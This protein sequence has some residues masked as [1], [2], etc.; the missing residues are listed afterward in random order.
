[1]TDAVQIYYHNDL[2]DGYT[3]AGS[4]DI[5]PDWRHPQRLVSAW[6][7][8]GLSALRANLFTLHVL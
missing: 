5:N 7:Y 8:Y 3:S 4:S 2:N 6:C 1:M